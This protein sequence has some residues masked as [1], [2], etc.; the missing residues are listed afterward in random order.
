M[1]V[2]SNKFSVTTGSRFDEEY[3]ED[4]NIK[5]R[6]EYWNNIFKKWVNERNFQANLEEYKSDDLDH[7]LSKFSKF[8]PLCH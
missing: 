8:C 1:E 7:A 6:M 5:Q 3:N 2:V 4:D